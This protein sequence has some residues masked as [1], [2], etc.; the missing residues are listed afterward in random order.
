LASTRKLEIQ[1]VGDYD[2]SASSMFRR[3][4]GDADESESRFSKWGKGI[5]TAVGVAFGIDAIVTWGGTLISA[6]EE[7]QKVTKQTDAVITSM[8]AS[9]W[10]TSKAIENLANKIS[11]KTGLDDEMIQSGENVLLTF[12]SVRNEVGKGNDVFDRATKVATDMSVA[13]GQD[14]QSSVVQ[15]G[16][17]LNDPIAGLT[18]LTRVGVQFTD[19][20]KAMIEQLVLSGDQL[21]AQKII[22]E[23]L[24]RQFGGSAE[25]QATASSKLKVA[26]DNVVETLGTALLPTFEKVAN[27]LAVEGPKAIETSIAWVKEHQDQLKILGAVILGIVVVALIIY[28]I[29]ALLAAAATIA[30]TW[31]ILLIVIA[32]AALGAILFYA[33][34]H[35]GWFKTAVEDAGFVILANI[36]VFRMMYDII[37]SVVRAVGQL[38]SALSR[39]PSPGSILSGLGGA[40]GPLGGIT[41][42]AR[43]L[44]GFAEGGTVPGQTG[45]PMLAV[46]HGGETIRPPGTRDSGGDTYITVHVA[47]SVLTEHALIDTLNGAMARGARLNVNGRYL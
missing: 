33:Y 29:N 47:G 43:K 24:E 35:W 1:I 15:I 38:I 6:A 28:T 9:S 36:G 8:G 7:A 45:A 39:I 26:W 5:A 30:A 12:A 21:G 42:T 44:F 2:A 18:S 14:L 16:K 40:A 3:A 22:L 27:W 46:V 10:T 34:T 19:E 23:E 41:L 31:P 11:L 20:Q 4:R 17:A 32:L 13:M 37:M 25:A